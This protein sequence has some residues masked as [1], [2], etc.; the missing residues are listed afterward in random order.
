MFA[1]ITV[2]S[3]VRSDLSPELVEV[4]HVFGKAVRRN[5]CGSGAHDVAAAVRR[6]HV[7][8]DHGLES[9]A[10]AFILDPRGNAHAIAARHVYEV[11]RRKATKVVRR[12]PL[13]PIGSLITCTRMSSPWFTRR[14]MSSTAG[15]DT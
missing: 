9:R 15:S 8:G 6:A 7:R 3:R 11:A 4:G 10:F 5:A 12:A 2:L 14:R 1:V 13:V